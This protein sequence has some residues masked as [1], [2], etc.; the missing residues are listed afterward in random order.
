METNVLTELQKGLERLTAEISSLKKSVERLQEGS[1]VYEVQPGLTQ[2]SEALPQQSVRNITSPGDAYQLLKDMESLEQ[3]EMRVILL[4]TRNHVLNIQTVF[5]GTADSSIV[6]PRDIFRRA[7]RKNAVNI[8]VAH[9]HPTG[10]TEPS[11]DD[12]RVTQQLSRAGDIIGVALL[13]HL[14]IGKAGFIS[15]K[16]Q[17]VMK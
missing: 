12:K 8:I 14:V 3:E 4:N 11:D 2:A 9:N 16:E 13:D 1:V 15:L 7:L 10:D 17:G 5:I 6:N